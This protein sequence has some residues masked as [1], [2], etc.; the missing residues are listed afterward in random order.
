[1]SSD[2]Q[3]ACNGD[4]RGSDHHYNFELQFVDCEGEHESEIRDADSNT[5]QPDDP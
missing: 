2:Q 3:G 5:D 1:M 4:S